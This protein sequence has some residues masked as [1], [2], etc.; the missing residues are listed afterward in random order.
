MAAKACNILITGANR[1]LGLEMVK[2][3]VAK[4]CSGCQIFAGC[5]DP[6]SA[7]S[8]DLRELAK[9][10]PSLIRIVKVDTS[11]MQSVADCAKKV[12]PLLGKGGLTLLVNNAG[13]M[14]HNNMKTI[15]AKEMQDIF[16]TNLLGP[17]MMTKEF[18]P[19]LQIA[20]KSSGKPGMSCSKAAVVNVSTVGAS[21]A[22]AHEM[23]ELFNVVGYR[24]SKAGLNMMTVCNALE[25]KEDGI[26]FV[27]LHPGW[28]RTDL[29]GHDAAISTTESIEGMLRVMESLTE[30]QNGAYL[31]YNG[32]VLPF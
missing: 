25:F 22:K 18:L 28:V 23:F 6:D 2:Q 24:I 12:G 13:V 1:G 10:H 31:D 29:G 4:S 5:R 20:A 11:N 8:Q 7:K 30:K 27:A 3:L 9:K 26:L 32:Q 19:Y 21:M 14:P 15:T 16:S 17:M